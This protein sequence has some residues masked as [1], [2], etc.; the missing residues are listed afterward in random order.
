MSPQQRDG[1]DAGP[2]GLTP[3]VLLFN[4]FF[5]RLT[6]WLLARK[7]KQLYPGS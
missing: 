7:M 4:K 5:P 2:G 3:Q 1:N 6:D